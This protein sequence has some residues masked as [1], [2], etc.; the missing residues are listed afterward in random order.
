M[1]YKSYTDERLITSKDALNKWE[2]KLKILEIE[3]GIIDPVSFKFGERVLVK[4]VLIVIKDVR[5]N[6]VEEREL[7]LAA[8]EQEVKARRG[9]CSSNRWV[10][11]TEVKNGYIV[12]MKH[13]ELLASAIALDYVVI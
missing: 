3:E 5:A 8:I 12:A 2:F 1:D 11:A 10:R 6:K 7:D 9:F 13:F 4:K